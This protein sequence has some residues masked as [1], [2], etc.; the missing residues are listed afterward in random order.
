MGRRE[1][2][3]RGGVAAEI[4]GPARP[5]REAPGP[6]GRR[7]S[8]EAVV[9]QGGGEHP[10]HRARPARGGRLKLC[11]MSAVNVKRVPLF[12]Q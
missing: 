7:R 6:A 3:G 2:P 8:L 10:Q 9:R 11:S 4:T 12:Q 5:R 1:A